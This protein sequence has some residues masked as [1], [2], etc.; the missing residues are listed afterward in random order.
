MNA[1]NLALL[2]VFAKLKIGTLNLSAI[3]IAVAVPPVEIPV[4]E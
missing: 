4:F 2:P 3:L 1:K